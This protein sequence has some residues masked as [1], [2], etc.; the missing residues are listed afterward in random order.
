MTVIKVLETLASTNCGVYPEWAWL[1][2]TELTSRK[3]SSVKFKAGYALADIASVVYAESMAN[4]SLLVK[5]HGTVTFTGNEHGPVES[6]VWRNIQVVKDGRLNIKSLFVDLSKEGAAQLGT[7]PGRQHLSFE[8]FR[9]HTDYYLDGHDYVDYVF[10]FRQLKARAKAI[11]AVLPQDAGSEAEADAL[12]KAAGVTASGFEALPCHL[13]KATAPKTEFRVSFKQERPEDN[14]DVDKSVGIGYLKG[15]LD[16]TIQERDDIARTLMNQRIRELNHPS[17][18][19]SF[20]GSLN[21]GKSSFTFKK[22]VC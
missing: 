4:V 3:C 17:W 15:L 1:G 14:T 12:L 19:D 10:K 11:K 22:A 18:G 13:P 16:F 6:F 9:L 2:T 5:V 7:A 8:E 21:G 20:D